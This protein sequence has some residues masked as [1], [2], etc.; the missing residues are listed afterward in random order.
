MI[1]WFWPEDG[2]FGFGFERTGY[3]L[4]WRDLGKG[5]CVSKEMFDSMY[6]APSTYF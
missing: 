3:L 6:K 5:T 2:G 1:S 4:L